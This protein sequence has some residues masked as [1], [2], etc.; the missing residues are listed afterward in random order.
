MKDIILSI[1]IPVYNAS[2]YL[3]ETMQSIV[4]NINERVEVIC[5][6]DGST[7]NSL[8]ILNEYAK[9]YNI[10]ILNQ[11]HLGAP[12]ARNYGTINAQ[13]DY[14]FYFD[15]DDVLERGSIEFIIS[16]LK[17]NDNDLLIFNY[18]IINERGIKVGERNHKN[19]IFA[20][21][22]NSLLLYFY[23]IPPFPGN[24]IYRKSIITNKDI[25]FAD[26]RIGQDL[27]FYLKYLPFSKNKKIFN[28]CISKYRLLP[29]SIS[30]SYDDRVL[31]IVKSLENV[32]DYYKKNNL[33]KYLNFLYFSEIGTLTFQCSKL[34]K[35]S[36]EIL[37]KSIF[38]EF[39][40]LIK[41]RLKIIKKKSLYEKFKFFQ[42]YTNYKKTKEDLL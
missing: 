16:E 41:E 9:K 34:Y 17:R 5:I 11:P 4:E 7:D 14:I 18:E 40:G 8:K 21:G 26:V 42:L 38:Y 24:K 6:D 13:G 2:A 36:D 22:K 20:K 19:H 32:Y 28:F 27:N 10:M 1:I 33:E 30:H 25:T 35:Y 31:D 12:A 37:K 3:R 39:D 29:K 15:A 23:L